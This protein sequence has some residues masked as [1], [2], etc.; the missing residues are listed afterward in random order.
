MKMKTKTKKTRAIHRAMVESVIASKPVLPVDR[1]TKRPLVQWKEHQTRLPT[2][3]EVL[4]WL[5]RFPDANIGMA[6]GALSGI[7]V[8]DCDSP[9]AT[10]RFTSDYPEVK[11]TLQVKTGRSGGCHFYFKHEEGIRNSVGNLLG[12]GIDVRA[13]GGL[14]IMPPSVHENGKRYKFINDKHPALLPEKLKKRLLQDP[15]RRFSR[16]TDESKPGNSFKDKGRNNF[17]TSLA[18]TMRRRGMAE[19]SILAGLLE[20]NAIKCSPP[21]SNDEVKR[22]AES[23]AKYDA[24][25]DVESLTDV[26]NASRL[27]RLHGTQLRYGH[28]IKQWYVWDEQRWRPDAAGAIYL[29]ARSVPRSLYEIAAVQKD[30][31]EG[32]HLYKHALRSEAE[33]RIRAM[34]SLAQSEPGIPVRLNELDSNPMLLN[35]ANG[36]IDLKTGKL[37]P[38]RPTDMITKL[39]PVP[40]D[41]KALCPTWRRFLDEIFDGNKDLIAYVQ[42]ATGYSL[43]A[44]VSEEVLFFLY[45]SGANGKTTLLNAIHDM[46]GEYATQSA[47]DVLIAKTN[48]S[49][50]TELA[51]LAGHRFVV[52]TEVEEGKHLAEALVKQLT[53]RD[54]IKARKMRQDFSEF[55]PTHKI[56]LAANQKPVVRGTDHGIWR[57]IHLIPFNVTFTEAEQD[58]QL[59]EKLRDEFPG[60]LAWA[61]QGCL[62]WQRS[63]LCPPAAVMGATET[64]RNEMDVVGSFME[65][66]L[67][68]RIGASISFIHLYQEY[69]DWCDRTGETAVNSRTF[70]AKLKGKGLVDR[71]GTKGHMKGRFEWLN[72]SFKKNVSSLL[73]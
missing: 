14:V 64:Y 44:D 16:S 35:V 60:I 43:T 41:P 55:D 48:P 15:I 5:R 21:L 20:E 2:K 67:I 53:G 27:V 70:T 40:Y 47:P 54:K 33:P 46:L 32:E 7:M 72:V 18:G 29:L 4:R 61:V 66:C 1:K 52:A 6:T 34:V 51:D 56:F 68:K 71:R 22:T 28:E 38:H 69:R 11:D 62:E 59:P 8:I 17:L 23:V 45:G 63:G 42:R 31:K 3:T 39:T 10:K 36:T 19:D 65:E 26:G 58:K 24:A 30:E 9:E 12:P 25:T 50:P 57:R 13:E 37:R 49:H 73:D